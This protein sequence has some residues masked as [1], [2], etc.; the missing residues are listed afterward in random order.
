M[1]RFRMDGEAAFRTLVRVSQDRN[2]KLTAVARE[3]T[4]TGELPGPA[5]PAAVPHADPAARSA[6]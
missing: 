4:E 3:L 6:T 2:R 1:E 5:Q